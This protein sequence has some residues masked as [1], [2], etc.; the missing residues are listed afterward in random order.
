[1]DWPPYDASFQI[2]LNFFKHYTVFSPLR[3]HNERG[4]YYS[5]LPSI[6]YFRFIRYLCRMTKDFQHI[7][8]LIADCQVDEAIKLLSE[9]ID[10]LDV[11]QRAHAY[12]L[13]GNAYGKL[14]NWRCAISCYCHSTELVPDGPA[15]EAYRRAIEI[16]DFY[17]HDLYNP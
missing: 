3:N 10:A 8:Q 15:A 12:Y 13:L 9:D 1:M 14:A 6:A 17:N 11:D 5:P 4:F 2:G 7:S 16:L